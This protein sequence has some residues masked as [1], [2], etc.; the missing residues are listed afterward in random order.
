MDTELLRKVQ[1]VQLEMLK[2]IKRVCEV[3]HVDYHLDSGTLLGA[4]RHNGFIP[5]DDD[6][7]IG[8]TRKN[9][10]RFLKEAPGVLDK[11]YFLQSWYSDEHYG[12]PFAKLRKNDTLYIEN[13]AHNSKAHNGF[14]VD[15]FPYDVYPDDVTEQRKM[16]RKLD[17]IRRSMLVKNGY[18]PFASDSLNKRIWKTI[19]YLPIDLY[20]A[21][22]SRKK[23]I[24]TYEKCKT[25][26]NGSHTE[27]YAP[28]G[29]SDFGRWVIPSDCFSKYEKHVFEDDEFSVPQNYDV[30]LTYAYGDYMIL[31]PENKRENR[32]N[33]LKVK[34]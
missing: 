30:Y 34:F 25:Q 6:L 26:Y 21:V 8:M 11:K 22:N 5:W 14:Y 18:K 10:V 32:H 13:N 3:I 16:A 4:V 33:I 19:I 17:F 2:E 31:P 12:L 23:L 24:E 28:A 9:Y 1:L 20:S 15:I 7:D 27:F 29:T